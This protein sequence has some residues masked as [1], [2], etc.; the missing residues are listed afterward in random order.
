MKAVLDTN[1][2]ISAVISTGTSHEV[3][4]EGFEGSYTIV[5]SPETIQEFEDTLLKYPDKF[6]MSQEE[7]EKERDTVEYFAEFVTP[8]TEIDVVEEDKSDNMFLEAAVSADAE[9]VVSGDTHLL[10]ID[11][12][13]GIEI[14]PPDEF[15]ERLDV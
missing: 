8:E 11:D 15:L 4:V 3:L 13:R 10:E 14:L 5:V 6:G 12:Y 1:V 7:V 9:Y 2:L